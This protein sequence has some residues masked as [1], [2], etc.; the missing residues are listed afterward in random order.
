MRI[1]KMFRLGCGSL[2]EVTADGRAMMNFCSNNYLG[3]SVHPRVVEAGRRALSRWGAGAGSARFICGTMDVHMELEEKLASFEGR[4]AAVVFA[5]GYM[6]N[7]G[8]LQAL[9]GPG[10]AV[11]CDRLNHASIIDG[12]RLSGARMLV[13]RH[14]DPERLEAVLARAGKY[15]SRLV[16]TDTVFSMDGDLAPLARIAGLCRAHGATLMVDEAHA[17]GVFG[18]R[19]RGLCEEAGLMAA[20]VHVKLGTLSKALGCAGGFVT[21]NRDLI[22]RVRNGARSFIYTT[23]PAPAVCACALEALAVLEDEGEALRKRLWGLVAFFRDSLSAMGVWDGGSRSQIFPLV[24]GSDENT[25]KL[26]LA[27]NEA[28]I[29]ATPILFPTVARGAGRV[30]L[31]V[32]AAHT[33][34]Q[35]GRCLDVIGKNRGLL[36]QE[37]ATAEGQ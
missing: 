7:A 21:G 19:G 4:E 10:G 3:L 14:A 20:D 26:A 34:E 18:A 30:R 23:A 37:P 16:V 27:L 15:A 36:A 32:T 28:G 24:C 9:C 13:Y 12:C 29:L 17:T 25:Q 33:R 11:V 1:R 2:A 22:E 35:I 31:T 8:T 5:A 6:A